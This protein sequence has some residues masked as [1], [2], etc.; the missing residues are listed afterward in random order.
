MA[1]MIRKVTVERGL[2][3]SRFTVFGYGGAGGL[4]VGSYARKLRCPHVVIP[5]EAAVFS[6]FGI[7]MS[8]VKRVAMVSDPARAPFDLV[9]WSRHFAELEATLVGQLHD[10]GLPTQHLLMRRSV[11]LQFH[12]QVHTVRVP[13]QQ[14]DLDAED[15]GAAL[16]DRF[17]EL[18]EARYGPGTAY[19]KVG[20]EALTFVVEGFAALPRRL[21]APLE[22]GD[23]DAGRGM[24]G[25][26]RRLPARGRR[27]H[28]HPGLPR[29]AT[30]AGQRIH[31]PGDRR[32]GGHDRA[33]PPCAV[34]MGRRL[35]QPSPGTR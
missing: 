31:R 6:A 1:D 7:S 16:V 27:I 35:P 24:R 17:T 33:R 19:R 29:R 21:P 10:E 34:V 28:C 12:G 4:H 32:G 18:Y 26:A 23:P 22:L 2:D 25:R 9:R 5:Q 20:V 13:V 11:E 15:G 30:D 8:D 14:A 3:P